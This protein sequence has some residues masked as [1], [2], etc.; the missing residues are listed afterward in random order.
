MPLP[1]RAGRPQDADGDAAPIRVGRRRRRDR[2]VAGRQPGQQIQAGVQ[3]HVDRPVALHH[4][5][6]RHPL[7]QDL[8]PVA[9]D[10]VGTVG[11]QL[12]QLRLL[13]GVGRELGQGPDLRPGQRG[14]QFDPRGEQLGDDEGR[15][16]RQVA[17]CAGVGADHHQ[18]VEVEFGQ[19]GG[20]PDQFGRVARQQRDVVAGAIGDALGQLRTRCGGWTGRRARSGRPW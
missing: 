18:F 6:Q 2:V 5:E 11:G 10:V 1:L 12:G 19:R 15:V 9:G 17:G 14:L 16:Q 4:V 3:R 13:A 8:L 20:P 7:E